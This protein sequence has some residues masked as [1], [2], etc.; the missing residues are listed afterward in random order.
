MAKGMNWVSD[1]KKLA[2]TK[3]KKKKR[4]EKNGE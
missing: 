2:N 3:K 4:M 1:Q